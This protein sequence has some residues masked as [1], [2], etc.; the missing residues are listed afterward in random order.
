MNYSLA[1]R[2][3]EWPRGFTVS[4][5]SEHS[6]TQRLEQTAEVV[7]IPVIDRI[8]VGLTRQSA[9]RIGDRGIDGSAGRE[10]ERFP[11]VQQSGLGSFRQFLD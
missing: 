9:F 8:V 5:Q 6:V 4:E 7:G 3:V 11:G 10:M 1:L 2:Q